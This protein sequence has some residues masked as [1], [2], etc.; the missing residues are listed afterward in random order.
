MSSP[1]ILEPPSVLTRAAEIALFRAY[2]ELKAE[3]QKT[4]LSYAWWLLEPVLHMS[5]YYVVIGKF[6]AR[7]TEDF[8]PFL[9]VGL[10][11]WRWFNTSVV[12]GASAITAAKGIVQN[13]GVDKTVFPAAALMVAL[14]KFALVFLILCVFLLG[15]GYSPSGWYLLLPVLAVQFLFQAGLALILAGAVPFLPDIKIVLE[16]AIKALF[17]LS[18][19]FYAGSS[20]PEA[21][22]PYFYMN[23]IASL[24]EAHRTV[25][26]TGSLPHVGRLAIIG[27]FGL[28]MILAGSWII[29]YKRGDFAKVVV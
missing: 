8:V 18:G 7:G 17:F 27:A 9:L 20:V 5:I 29:R 4:Y 19:I 21:Y 2:A 15:Y 16:N 22:Q 11:V 12:S 10:V 24:I 14:F 28:V 3:G 23:P 25:L 26:L 6:L 1:T 13:V